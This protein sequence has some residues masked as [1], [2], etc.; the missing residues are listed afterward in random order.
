M[1]RKKLSKIQ[2]K[3]K[4]K[5]AGNVFYDLL[6]DKVGH[7]DSIVPISIGKLIEM[8][9]AMHTATKRMK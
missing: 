8:D 7:S 4:L 5:Q 6:M 1:P 3:R 9:K 2:V